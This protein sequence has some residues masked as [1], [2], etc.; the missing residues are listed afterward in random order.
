M[1]THL[2]SYWNLNH[3]ILFNIV[4]NAIKFNK[5]EARIEI[6]LSLELTPAGSSLIQEGY[7]I[8]KIKD[9][10]KGIEN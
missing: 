8:T 5:V 7:L 10:G 4:H 6:S 9:T 3:Q 1:P 2:N